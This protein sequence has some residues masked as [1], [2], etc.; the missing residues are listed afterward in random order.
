MRTSTT[1]RA[2]A[3]RSSTPSKM[4]PKLKPHV[5][6]K[7][8][9]VDAGAGVVVLVFICTVALAV[10]DMRGMMQRCA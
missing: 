9:G 1:T 8:A 3:V 2:P 6:Q 5:K 4:C 7:G 10:V